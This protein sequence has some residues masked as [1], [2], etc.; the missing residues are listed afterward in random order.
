MAENKLGFKGINLGCGFNMWTF[1]AFVFAVWFGTIYYSI[2]TMTSDESTDMALIV[3]AVWLSVNVV[4]VIA[5]GTIASILAFMSVQAKAQ[6]DA[7]VAKTKSLGFLTTIP[8]SLPF[9]AHVIKNAAFSRSTSNNFRG[10][11]IS[12]HKL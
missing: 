3:A 6:N 11:F 4:G 7:F 8:V 10:G 1:F 5:G 9:L 2:S 12:I